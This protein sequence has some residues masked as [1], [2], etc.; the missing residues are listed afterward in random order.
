MHRY[1][2]FAFV[3]SSQPTNLAK[4]NRDPNHKLPLADCMSFSYKFGTLRSR[5]S[6]DSRARPGVS[7]YE[8]EITGKAEGDATEGNEES[9]VRFSPDLVDKRIKASLE[10]LH[11]QI[12]VLT[13]M[14]DRLIQSN[15]ARETTTASSRETRHQHESPYS[16]VPG[17]ARFPTVA[18]LSTAGYSPD[19]HFFKFLGW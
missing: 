18:P 7:A 3:N 11:A 13:E 8:E 19:N 9:K 17:F 14:M 4:I 1:L 15:S 6:Y 5:N 12:S 10:P 2:N 16:G